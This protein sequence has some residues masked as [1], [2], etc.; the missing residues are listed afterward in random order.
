MPALFNGYQE[1]LPDAEVNPRK[2]H[3]NL[4]AGVSPA[5][6]NGKKRF[7]N[8][9]DDSS[10]EDEPATDGSRS[11]HL[12]M[13]R[14]L[15][16]HHCR[17]SLEDP[18]HVPLTSNLS[19]IRRQAPGPMEAALT[20][21]LDMSRAFHFVCA[22]DFGVFLRHCF[23]QMRLDANP[24]V[25]ATERSVIAKRVFL[26]DTGCH[27]MALR[28]VIWGQAG[29]SA[30]EHEVTVYDPN[31][32]DHHVQ[33]FV[34]CLHEFTAFPRD[35]HF[36]SYITPQSI[37]QT[38]PLSALGLEYF[39]PTQNTAFQMAL[40]ELRELGANGPPGQ[41]EI[42]WSACP[43]ASHY[44][45]VSA[46]CGSTSADYLLASLAQACQ[47][48]DP[49]LLKELP[50]FDHSLLPTLMTLPVAGPIRQ[51]REAW[52]TADMALKVHLLGGH[53][54]RGKPFLFASQECHPECLAE[55]TAM[56]QTLAPQDVLGVLGAT[57]ASGRNA[58]ELALISPQVLNALDT[59]LQRCAQTH[60]K[61]IGQLLAHADKQ[62][63]TALQ[64]MAFDASPEGLATWMKWLV[65]WADPVDLPAL[66]D[67]PDTNETHALAS[68]RTDK[69]DD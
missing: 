12:V 8:S 60:A 37:A 61:E 58:L 62:G 3:S 35:H 34:P 48:R 17:R 10:D 25:S 21:P 32:T 36:F 20:R 64:N 44:L 33:A 11:G 51:W 7:L 16:L 66:L 39:E 43:R 42:D 1:S 47:D 2:P 67:M 31:A 19:T 6:L 15:A 13:C 52:E 57:D 59:V 14:H 45:A 41:L 53:D 56:L 27:N 38:A 29:S 68:G 23:N 4:P 40:F 55:W 18:G 9:S 30:M 49:A 46:Q 50:G 69:S 5:E 22:Q 63:R 28:L 26:L 24:A 65:D 54:H